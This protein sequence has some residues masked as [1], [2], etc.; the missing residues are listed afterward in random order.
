M[1]QVHDFISYLPEEFT[2]N[3][4]PFNKLNKKTAKELENNLSNKIENHYEN[5]N[6]QLKD[7]NKKLNNLEN[8]LT[9]K[10]ITQQEN[11]IKKTPQK[12]QE[13]IIL[14]LTIP[15]Q[16]PQKQAIP[17]QPKL[18]DIIIKG[19]KCQLKSSEYNA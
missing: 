9:Q 11:P 8:T 14:E 19:Q 13:P 18:E 6:N 7:I 1:L 4:Q 2:Q 5:L 10:T 16:I 3:Y 15:Q 17:Q 12:I